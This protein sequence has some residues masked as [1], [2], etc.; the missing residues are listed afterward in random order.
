M[1]YQQFF[2]RDSIAH[3]QM[4]LY[5]KRD[6]RQ[7]MSFLSIS[8]LLYDKMEKI[9]KHINWILMTDNLFI[10][11]FSPFFKEKEEEEGD[12]SVMKEERNG[13]SDEN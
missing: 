5:G 9:V 2:F 13:R 12:T 3:K 4:K 7:N 6:V 10:S 8:N 1:S 11:L